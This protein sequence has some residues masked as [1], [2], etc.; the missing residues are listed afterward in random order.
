M[1]D[2]SLSTN[3]VNLAQQAEKL[4][5]AGV[6]RL[7]ISLDTLR[8]DRFQAISQN[9]R[10][11]DV[12][13]GIKVAQQLGFSPIKINCVVMQGINDDEIEAMTH[14][15]QHNELELRFIE[16]MPIG[17]SGIQQMQNHY[18]A[19]KIMQRLQTYLGNDLLPAISKQG[20]GPA[21]YYKVKGS[22]LGI[23][24][25]T[26]VSQHFCATCNRVRLTSRGQLAL[27]LGQ[28]N[29][30]DLRTPVRQ[31]ATV[32]DIEKIIKDAIH[33]KPERH[34]FNENRRNIAFRQMVSIGG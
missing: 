13:N 15:A 28:E 19:E 27:C 29:A 32:S 14:W 1:I 24:L 16:V 31:G 22:D 7:N 23:G 34:F 4:Y 18:P 26:A 9:D 3:A 12:F 6:K 8:A 17:E 2:L 30:I 25:I 21:K 11:E 20:A 5:Q 33:L 10:I